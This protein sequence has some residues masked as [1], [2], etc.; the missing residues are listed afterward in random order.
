M[1]VV[2]E[3]GKTETPM[4]EFTQQQLAQFDPNP[5]HSTNVSSQ[6][7]YEPQNKRTGVKR[8]IYIIYK[9]HGGDFWPLLQLQ[10][11]MPVTGITPQQPGFFIPT[12]VYTSNLRYQHSL[13]PRD[14]RISAKKSVHVAFQC[15]FRAKN[16]QIH[17]DMGQKTPIFSFN[18]K[19]WA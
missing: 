11:A 1:V 7:L 17:R 6:C 10:A 14:K 13:K 2:G 18:G 3:T 8:E 12:H 9:Y 19:I 16:R 4:T 15:R 5:C